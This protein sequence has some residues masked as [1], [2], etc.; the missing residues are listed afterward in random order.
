MEVLWKDTHID[1]S[2]NLTKLSQFADTYA[3]PTIDKAT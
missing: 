2:E 1:P 3:T